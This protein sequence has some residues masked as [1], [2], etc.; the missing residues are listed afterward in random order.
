M[1]EKRPREFTFLW[2]IVVLIA[3]FGGMQLYWHLAERFARSDVAQFGTWQGGD[4]VLVQ[5]P[6]GGR[7]VFSLEWRGPRQTVSITQYESVRPVAQVAKDGRLAMIVS[8]D[9]GWNLKVFDAPKGP[10]RMLYYD[11]RSA[12]E[13]ALR[14]YVAGTFVSPEPWAFAGERGG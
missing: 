8:V 13:Q 9:G 4:V 10:S 3:A 2:V 1:G 11:D 12:V 6:L 14:D 7:D 5:E